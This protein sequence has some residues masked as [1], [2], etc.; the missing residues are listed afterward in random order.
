ML[1]DRRFIDPLRA[2]DPEATADRLPEQEGALAA[3]GDATGD[4]SVRT[5]GPAGTPRSP[6][7]VIV[8]ASAGVPGGRDARSRCLGAAEGT[9]RLA[10]AVRAVAHLLPHPGPFAAPG[11]GAA[12]GR[13]D[14]HRKISLAPHPRQPGL[15]PAFHLPDL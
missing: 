12:A 4:G 6:W 10:A 5:N 1:D 3:R 9:A 2:R 8:R 13:A 7:R 15:R 11:K 14:P